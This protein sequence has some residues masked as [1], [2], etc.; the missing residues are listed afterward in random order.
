MTSTGLVL[1]SWPILLNVDWPV[2]RSPLQALIAEGKIG[3]LFSDTMHNT[4]IIRLGFEA[5]EVQIEKLPN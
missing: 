5:E 4:H 2:L 1:E 3:A